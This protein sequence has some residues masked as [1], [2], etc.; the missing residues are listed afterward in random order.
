MMK[1]KCPYCEVEAHQLRTLRNMI[2]INEETGEVISVTNED[3]LTCPHCGSSYS[4]NWRS[5]E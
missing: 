1:R 2:V 4:K 5:H 3:F